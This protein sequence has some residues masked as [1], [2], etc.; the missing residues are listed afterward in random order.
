MAFERESIAPNDSALTNQPQIQMREERVIDPYRQVARPPK[1]GQSG[2]NNGTIPGAAAETATAPA[3]E[4]V[5]LSPAAAAL[6]RKEQKFRQEQLALK[7]KETAL[8]KERA[9][10]A[11]FKALKSKL[12][13]KD[14]AA[15][16]GMV[17]Y[18]EY[19]NYH[20]NK[21]NGSSPEAQKLTELE[22][23]LTTLQKSQADDVSKRFEAAVNERRTA[24]KTLVESDVQFSSIKELKAE[25][26]VVQH[27]LD[28]WEKDSVDL[29]P[30]QAAKEVEE[31]ILERAKKWSALSKITPKAEPEADKKNELPPLKASVKTLTNDMTAVGEIKRPQKSLHGMSDSER[32]AEARRRAE[33]KLKPK[34]G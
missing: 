7:A 24:V 2:I 23:K 33:E 6:A 16:E 19:T 14:Y 9:E 25:E 21:L 29:T 18:D 5:S 8:E 12:D 22:E 4:S 3:A 27:I 17:P 30:E 31:I 20:V 32:W 26:A 34:Q 10:I 1:V 28:T 15:I 13:A 11:E